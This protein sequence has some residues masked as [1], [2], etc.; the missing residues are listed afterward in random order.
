MNNTVVFFIII[1]ILILVMKNGK[2]E[3]F[4]HDHWN[5][6]CVR[7]PNNMIH[8]TDGMND[9]NESTDVFWKDPRHKALV[10]KC[11]LKA[12]RGSQL[13]SAVSK[14]A[15][16]TGK[17][18]YLQTNRKTIGGQSIGGT[19]TDK[20]GKR[21]RDRSFNTRASTGSSSTTSAASTAAG[22]GSTI[23]AYCKL[24]EL[25]MTSMTE[26]IA[27]AKVLDITALGDEVKTHCK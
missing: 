11:G 13:T 1:A 8:Q 24:L 22:S 15:S 3:N 7:D 5:K 18:N 17:T 9:T 21:R 25:K 2:K 27:T 26:N 20:S 23:S 19:Y 12:D 6:D 10:D 14:W 16:T 4:A